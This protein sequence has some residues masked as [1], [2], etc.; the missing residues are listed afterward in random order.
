M[1]ALRAVDLDDEALRDYFVATLRAADPANRSL[2]V[3][4][5]EALVAGLYRA[6]ATACEDLEPVI[7]NLEA[8]AARAALAAQQ[9]AGRRA[10]L[11]HA[12]GI[13]RAIRGEVVQ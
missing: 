5:A 13:E 3:P 12:L 1:S 9:S 6:I 11:E 4:R 2:A 7:A 8:R 10:G